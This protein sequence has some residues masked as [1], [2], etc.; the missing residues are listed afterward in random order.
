MNAEMIWINYYND[1]MNES[2][3]KWMN[4]WHNEW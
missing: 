4:E 1:G 2:H 3:N